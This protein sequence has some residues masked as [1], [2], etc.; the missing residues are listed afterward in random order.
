[1]KIIKHIL[2][3]QPRSAWGKQPYIDNG[4]LATATRL[5]AAGMTYSIV[6]L[7]VDDE[8]SHD[9]I[10]QADAVGIS[11]IGCPFIPPA[12]TLAKGIR[13]VGY[14][15]PIFFGGPMAE[16]I[17]RV[18]WELLFKAHA[19]E[20]I[21]VIQDEVELK[22]ALGIPTMP[23]IY[24]CSM[25]G[26]I[27]ALPEYMQQA[28]FGKEFCIFTSNGCMF[29]CNFCGALKG[30]PETFRDPDA[31][32]DEV[33]TI[34]AMVRKYAGTSTENEIY[35]STLDGS[36]NR[37]SME[38]TLKI[39]SEEFAKA[40][41]FAPL[42]FLATSKFTHDNLEADPDILKRWYGYGLRCIGIGVDGDDE[43][44]WRRLRKTH[45]KRGQIEHALLGIQDAGMVAEAFM[46]FGSRIESREA[47]LKA[48]KACKRLSVQGIKMRPHM[49]KID[50]PKRESE[51]TLLTER[52]NIQPYLSNINLFY[53][54]DYMMLASELTHPDKEQ[55]DFVNWQYRGIIR[56][57]VKNNPYGCPSIP[58]LPTEDGGEAK[59]RRA[60][61]YNESVPM[62]R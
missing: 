31:F 52:F 40:G 43:E 1:M 44:T 62:D 22:I 16:T 21:Q 25:A 7:N 56:W 2:L 41:T 4:L 24:A 47:T 50:A 34:A 42:R 55:R 37:D 48:V 17:T 46:I 32:R 60:Y 57:L 26:T 13:E 36:Q 11:I 14:N 8:I 39:I 51:K 30:Q 18:N 12:F 10:T 45:N 38:K 19:I 9:L 27:R 3:L 49:A 29:N 20:G 61:S 5:S 54:Q 59:R 15:G 23:S 35:L 53:H 33:A 6:D 58:L 28:Y